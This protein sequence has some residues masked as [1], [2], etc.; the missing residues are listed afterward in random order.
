MIKPKLNIKNTS[1]LVSISIH[2]LALLIF[3]IV[4]GLTAKDDLVEIRFG[5]PGGGSGGYG[6]MDKD[7]S[8]V[9]LPLG[10]VQQN[11]V[12]E[13]K[14]EKSIDVPE[15]TS[16]NE[17]DDEKIST[18]TEKIEKNKNI[19]GS[20]AARTTAGNNP[21]GKGIGNGTG[22]GSGVGNGNG[23]G[24]GNGLGDGFGIDWGGRIRKIYNYTIPK[25]P[26]GVYK[27]IDVKLRFS[28][29]PDGSVGNILVLKKADSRLEQV[30]IDALRMWRFEPLPGNQQQT[31]QAVVITF[32]FRLE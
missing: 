26:E 17:K 9:E 32:P 15:L 22:T 2:L 23:N 12:E 28:I 7:Y 25:Y 1:T 11:A 13:T 20:D 31:A 14:D 3:F 24:F 30:A 21:Y 27:N 4:S 18:S 5:E 6:P 16:K 8:M 10:N 29:L 19:K